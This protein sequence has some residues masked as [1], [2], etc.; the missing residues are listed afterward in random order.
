MIEIEGIKMFSYDSIFD[1]P[2]NKKRPDIVIDNNTHFIIV[3][4]NEFQHKRDKG[5][6]RENV[7][8]FDIAYKR[9]KKVSAP[10]CVIY[11]FD[12]IF[13]L[14]F[15]QKSCIVYSRFSWEK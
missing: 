10:R 7:R 11:L 8:M 5:Y 2:C 12:R 13:L 15:R 1:K 9:T 14:P 4:L 6:L 3:E